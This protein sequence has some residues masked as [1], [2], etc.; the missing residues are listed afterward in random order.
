MTPEFLSW[1]LARFEI[2]EV[3]VDET[4]AC[5]KADDPT[6]K[7]FGDERYIVCQVTYRKK[8]ENEF[9]KPRYLIAVVSDSDLSKEGDYCLVSL[10]PCVRDTMQEKKLTMDLIAPFLSDAEKEKIDREYVP[11]DKEASVFRVPSRIRYPIEK[12]YLFVL[13]DNWIYVANLPVRRYLTQKGYEAARKKLVDY[14]ARIEN[15][16]RENGSK[17]R[18]CPYRMDSVTILMPYNGIKRILAERHIDVD[19][20]SMFF[21]KCYGVLNE[22]VPHRLTKTLSNDD[23][24]TLKSEIASVEKD[25]AFNKL[26]M[27]DRLKLLGYMNVH[28][29]L[30]FG[31]K[32]N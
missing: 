10:Y 20:G 19:E 12:Q 23:L 22:S 9:S 5:V 18:F 29:V 32:K 28:D 7:R 24:K 26:K 25:C 1:Y 6:Q 8:E 15:F 11:C 14:D 21:H 3:R 31:I 30:L 4:I 16:K 2:A 17:A 27:P 13:A